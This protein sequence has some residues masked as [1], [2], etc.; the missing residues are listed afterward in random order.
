MRDIL[1]KYNPN[2]LWSGWDT[3][4][5]LREQEIENCYLFKKGLCQYRHLCYDTYLKEIGQ[6]DWIFQF[7]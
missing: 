1:E 3:S 6:D 2:I 7:S 4:S 5:M